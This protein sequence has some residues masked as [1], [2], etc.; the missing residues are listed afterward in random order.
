MEYECT[1][2]GYEMGDNTID[3]SLG[4]DGC[5]CKTA[6]LLGKMTIDQWISGDFI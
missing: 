4:V 6:L 3:I 1:L 5:T 2:L